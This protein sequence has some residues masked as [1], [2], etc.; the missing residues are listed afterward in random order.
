MSASQRPPLDVI[1][2]LGEKTYFKHALPSGYDTEAL[3]KAAA[4]L[5]I[6]V[7]EE[8]RKIS[9]IIASIKQTVSKKE[10][11]EMF[12]K[13][14]ELSKAERRDVFHNNLIITFDSIPRVVPISLCDE[15]VPMEYGPFD[16]SDPFTKREKTKSYKLGKQR[17]DQSRKVKAEKAAAFAERNPFVKKKQE[18][19]HNS[20]F[21]LENYK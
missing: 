5:G 4:A 9:E 17:R 7:Q 11:D 21:N 1:H 8:Q 15:P 10:M 19:P 20:I 2:M 6:D 16:L 18:P 13:I 3:F 14:N 12:K